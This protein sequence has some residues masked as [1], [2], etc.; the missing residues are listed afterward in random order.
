[1][2]IS[3]WSSVV[4]SS[5]LTTPASPVRTASRSPRRTTPRPF[6]PRNAGPPKRHSRAY[7]P[8]NP[9]TTSHGEPR[10]Q[11]HLQPATRARLRH[12]PRPG[13]GRVAAAGDARAVPDVL[14]RH[15]ATE[16]GRAHV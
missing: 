4:S 6:P 8:Q 5:D 3:D 12:L 10:E 11:P 1:M 14:Q 2:R 9:R 15:A 13:H 7:T 16:I